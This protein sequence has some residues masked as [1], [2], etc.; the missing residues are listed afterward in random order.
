M[1]AAIRCGNVRSRR[2]DACLPR[3]CARSCGSCTGHGARHQRNWSACVHGSPTRCS[4]GR[5]AATAGTVQITGG[6]GVAGRTRDPAAARRPHH[7]NVL[8]FGA[9]GWLAIDPKRLLGDRAF[10]YTTMFSNPDLCG[11]GIH[12]ATRPE[13]FAAR[14][15]QVSALAGWNARACCAGSRPALRCRRCGSGMTATPPT[16]TR[17]WRGWRWR[18]WRRRDL[19]AWWAH[20]I[21]DHCADDAAEHGLGSTGFF[22]GAHLGGHAVSGVD[23]PDEDRQPVRPFPSCTAAGAGSSA[24]TR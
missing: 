14:L 21:R 3:F 24:S 11:P 7:D 6:A 19:R 10:D 18:R 2:D 20:S 23:V 5:A 9:R 16:S 17:R 15:Q 13:R 12:V 1:P 4:Q 8:D 22:V